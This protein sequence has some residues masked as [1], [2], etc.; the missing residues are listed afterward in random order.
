[1]F[2]RLSF[3]DKGHSP[4]SH[5]GGPQLGDETSPGKKL[6]ESNSDIDAGQLLQFLLCDGNY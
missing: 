3:Q 5:H 2:L 1:M 4:Q 6:D